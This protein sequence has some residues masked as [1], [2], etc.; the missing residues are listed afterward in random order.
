MST[1]KRVGPKPRSGSFMSSKQISRAAVDGRYLTFHTSVR[2]V[3]GYV[4]GMD[5]Y[6]WLIA[7]GHAGHLVM[8][9]KGSTAL[10]EFGGG[11]NLPDRDEAFRDKVAKIGQPF[12][13]SI[14]QRG[15]GA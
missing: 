3:E 9:H 12:W 13:D 14:K 10:V 2:T 7:D 5:D 1:A 6:H 11:F 8:V 4:V 15:D